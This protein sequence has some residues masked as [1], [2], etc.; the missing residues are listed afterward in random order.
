MTESRIQQQLSFFLSP[1]QCMLE[2]GSYARFLLKEIVIFSPGWL[3]ARLILVNS[4]KLAREK[5]R[6]D[7]T[8]F[9]A[10]IYKDRQ[11]DNNL[12]RTRKI[13]FETVIYGQ[14]LTMTGSG[15]RIY[16]DSVIAIIHKDGKHLQR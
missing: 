10:R 15:T 13:F 3:G 2:C 11:R 12:E 1:L 4:G 8:K 16:K 5:R 6:N 7:G 9:I 14:E